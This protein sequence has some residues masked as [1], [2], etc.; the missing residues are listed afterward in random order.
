MV[1]MACEGIGWSALARI[2]PTTS[3]NTFVMVITELMVMDTNGVTWD[4]VMVNEQAF[5]RHNRQGSFNPIR[6]F[7]DWWQSRAVFQG[8]KTRHDISAAKRRLITAELALRIF[9]SEHGQP[10]AQLSDLVPR[11]LPRVPI[12]PFTEKELIYRPQGTNWLLYSV[13]EDGTDDGG[14]PAS[15]NRGAKGD[16][17]FNLP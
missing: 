5:I 4:A 2:A 1:G 7:A 8:A 10:P 13:G 9:Q 3:S 14:T 15:R 6:R 11:Y 12:D 17:L 16:L